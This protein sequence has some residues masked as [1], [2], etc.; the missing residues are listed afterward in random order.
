M[1][2]KHQCQIKMVCAVADQ[3]KQDHTRT[4]AYSSLS[5]TLWFLHSSLAST[6]LPPE[7]SS[8][9]QTSLYTDV[10]RVSNAQTV[11]DFTS[12]AAFKASYQRRSEDWHKLYG[13]H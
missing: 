12:S 7:P 3:E 2:W 8:C 5:S 6:F 1:A 4:S 13:D 9:R 11:H 10:V